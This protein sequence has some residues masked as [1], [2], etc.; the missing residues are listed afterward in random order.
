MLQDPAGS[1]TIFLRDPRPHSCKVLNKRSKISIKSRGKPSGSCAKGTRSCGKLARSWMKG[2][3]SCGKVSRSW[4]W[5]WIRSWRMYSRWEIKVHIF[6]NSHTKHSSIY[7]KI[8]CTKH[9]KRF[10][11]R[12]N[13]AQWDA[14]YLI[15]IILTKCILPNKNLPRGTLLPP[16]VVHSR[17]LPEKQL[18]IYSKSLIYLLTNNAE[19]TW[20]S[21]HSSAKQ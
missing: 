12:V 14:G 15:L 18:H 20:L 21:F 11:F 10:T 17:L 8:S 19:F 4:K 1:C 16:L 5:S 6:E 7:R 2:T 9:F 3:R 13:S